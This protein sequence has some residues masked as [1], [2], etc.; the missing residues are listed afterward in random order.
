MSS[1]GTHDFVVIGAGNAGI[2]AARAA[3]AA[4]RSVLLVERRE[5]G[6]TCPLRGCVPKKVLVAAAELMDAIARAH[7]Q[8]VEVGPARIDWP[9][10]I[11]R[12]QTFVRDVPEDMQRS[13]E[14]RGVRIAQ[15]EAR[16]VGAN[17]IE[18]SGERQ[19][20]ARFVI[21][22]GSRPRPL[23]FEGAEL[24]ATSDDVLELGTLPRE[25]VFI[26][27]GVIALELGHVLARAGARVTMLEAAA[28]PLAGF[29]PE[30]VDALLDETRRLGVEIRCGVKVTKL[31]RKGERLVVHAG[32]ELTA[33]LVVNGAGRIADLDALDLARAG[34]ELDSGRPELDG[35]L[36][37]RQNPNIAF[38]GD[39]L[40][41]TPQL[42]PIATEEGRLAVQNLI[43]EVEPEVL[44]YDSIP[45][46][47]F[48]VPAL[49]RVGLSEA[50]A[51]ERELDFELRQNDL[52]EWRAGRTY[53]ETAAMSK[54]LI[55]NGSGR[56]L[57]AHLLGH[58]AQETIHA[59]AFHMRHGLP[60]SELRSAVS[61]YPTFHADLRHML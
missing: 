25:I 16:F 28:R 45:S 46:V 42:S 50:E 15:G 9:R 8:G 43:G 7:E 47:V 54:L 23:K 14:E 6:G 10:L 61:A 17:E 20:G 38:A 48:S 40:A 59:F 52:R 32:G 22:V 4:G 13:L 58:G 60:A 30:L 21:A 27:A 29:D 18:V 24:C 2:A 31:E 36:R 11:E 56:I 26:G 1:N 19:R 3:R 37:S 39:A 53:A 44:D 33:D 57:G 34:I 55:E 49:A 35:H 51:R 12:K 5:I 41:G